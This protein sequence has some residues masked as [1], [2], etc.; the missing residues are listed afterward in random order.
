MTRRAWHIPLLAFAFTF[1][2]SSAGYA[3]SSGQSA[4]EVLR[5]KAAT[6]ARAKASEAAAK[7]AQARASKIRAERE[8][9]AADLATLGQ[10]IVAR[11]RALDDARARLIALQGEVT[12]AR[13]RLRDTQRRLEMFLGR[14]QRAAREPTPSLLAH[15]DRPV[16]AA[17]A[18]LL[19]RGLTEEMRAAVAERARRLATIASASAEAESIQG[20]ARAEIAGLI[21]DERAVRALLDQKE[22]AEALERRDAEAAAQKAAALARRARSL[23]DLATS[24]QRAPTSGRRLPAPARPGAGDFAAAKGSLFAPAAGRLVRGSGRRSSGLYIL[25]RSHARVIAPW[26]G[27]VRYADEF[28]S[29]GKIVII[30]PQTGY[31]LV[32][33]GLERLEVKVGQQVSAG[34]PIGRMGGPAPR[35]GEFLFEWTDDADALRERLYLEIWEGGAPVGAAPWLRKETK[36]VSGL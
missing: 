10:S 19:M 13:V 34:Q 8:R 5:Q 20:A 3:Q 12:E 16:H 21:E 6:D 9:L 29:E 7:A 31:S 23:G 35:G 2:L 32:I 28:M 4:D 17:R 11:E 26:S 30:E 15:P 25:T 24:L 27:R 33:A 22:K 18:A 36:R 1:G 14:A